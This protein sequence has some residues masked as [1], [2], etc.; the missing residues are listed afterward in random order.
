M[1][2]R[3]EPSLAMT[4]KNGGVSSPISS[5]GTEGLDGMTYGQRDPRENSF[6]IHTGSDSDQE[7]PPTRINPVKAHD[8]SQKTPK[9]I[10]RILFQ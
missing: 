8:L 3:K 2:W 7:P 9:Q 6:G 10:L 4:R 1:P 5:D